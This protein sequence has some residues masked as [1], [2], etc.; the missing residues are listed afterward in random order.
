MNFLE[1]LSEIVLVGLITIGAIV[2]P[3][4]EPIVE[5]PAEVQEEVIVGATL[6]QQNALIDTY[7]AS[8]IDN[9][10]TTMTLADGTLRDGT[11]ISGYYCF[12][13]D[14]NTPVLEYI[15]GDAVG[16]S[17][18]NLQRGVMVSNPNA[19][20]SSL[21][22]SHRRFAT[23]QVTDFPF[24]QLVQR[25]LNGVDSFDNTLSYSS[26]V[27][28]VDSGDLVDVE[29]VLDTITGTS[30][31]SY[32]RTVISGTAGETLATG[33]VIYLKPSDQEW[34]TIDVDDTST[35]I[36]RVLG[37]AQGVGTNG[38]QIVRGILTYG[39]DSNQTGLTAGSFYFAS[40]SAGTLTTSTTTQ[41]LGVAK[42]TTE[43]FFDPKI[44]DSSIYN[45]VSF[46]GTTTFTGKV[47]GADSKAYLLA[48][49]TF[50]G[51]TSPQAAY[52]TASGTATTSNASATSTAIFSGFIITNTATGSIA[53]M[54]TSG[55]VSGFSGLTQ[56][57]KYYI[58]NTNGAIAPTGGTFS[59]LVG[60]AIS[61]TELLIQKAPRRA[62]GFGTFQDDSSTTFTIGF[63]ASTIRV[64][65][66]TLP[67]SATGVLSHGTFINGIQTNI[68]QQTTNSGVYTTPTVGTGSVWNITNT[69]GGDGNT[70][71]VSV[72]STTI[73]FTN[74]E[75]GTING[76]VYSWEA[77]E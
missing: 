75:T 18:T 54:Q 3:T 59:T 9:S 68:S 44:I 15:C 61:A 50:T 24:N 41:P 35:Y 8:N 1:K 55:V 57:S 45:D 67:G 25:K 12:T 11:T 46:T 60:T 77:E 74:D 52:I 13:V 19:T 49:S 73:T 36:D 47:N 33:T 53:T 17:V 29:Y 7:L 5:A 10:Q 21:A 32:N 6:P 66:S 27:T 30:T 51:L 43:L 72:S 69:D 76:G 34:Y 62:S 31:L 20:S 37:I 42:S 28:P 40:T 26:S 63:R 16:T 4:G 22:Y 38:N 58:T 23:V 2:T 56:G 71:T 14:I 65:A 64:S 48:S 70:G 39:L